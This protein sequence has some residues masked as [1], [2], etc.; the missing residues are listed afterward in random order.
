MP[1]NQDESVTSQ[2][3]ANNNLTSSSN[4]KHYFICTYLLFS[5][6]K[7]SC[8]FYTISSLQSVLNILRGGRLPLLYV[9]SKGEFKSETL[10]DDLS[11]DE[12][13]INNI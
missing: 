4:S 9:K 6:V 12:N 3:Y 5:W 10:L 8:I 2:R 11:K 13:L 1:C 7:V